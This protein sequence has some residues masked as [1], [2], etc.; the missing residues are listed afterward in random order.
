MATSES[1]FAEIKK[2]LGEKEKL[3]AQLA[4]SKESSLTAQT[5]S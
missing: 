1:M 2:Q 3:Q 4:E 5:T